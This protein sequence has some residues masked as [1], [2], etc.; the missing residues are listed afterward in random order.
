MGRNE[1]GTFLVTRPSELI[2]DWIASRV[3]SG[4]SNQRYRIVPGTGGKESN[5]KRQ[6]KKLQRKM[7]VVVTFIQVEKL[8]GN[9]RGIQSDLTHV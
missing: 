2:G 8:I 4:L 5:T 7:N 1:H 3:F 9:I 6:R